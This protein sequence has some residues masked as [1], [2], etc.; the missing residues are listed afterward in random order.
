MPLSV[1]CRRLKIAEDIF[2]AAKSGSAA[3]QSRA[4]AS[5]TRLQLSSIPF[6]AASKTSLRASRDNFASARDAILARCVMEAT[7]PSLGCDG[8]VVGWLML[9]ATVRYCRG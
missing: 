9:F 4:F 7:D 2:P 8:A 6:A 1:T 5:R 3:A